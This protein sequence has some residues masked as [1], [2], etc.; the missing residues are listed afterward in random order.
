MRR[1]AFDLVEGPPSVELRHA[2]D[3]TEFNVPLRTNE[4]TDKLQVRSDDSS[5]SVKLPPDLEALATRSRSKK[6]PPR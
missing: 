1:S 3:K 2:L 4:A 5:G 6:K